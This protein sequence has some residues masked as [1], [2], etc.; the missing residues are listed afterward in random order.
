MKDPEADLESSKAEAYQQM[1]IAFSAIGALKNLLRYQVPV[2]NYV[3]INAV[4][5]LTNHLLRG[6]VQLL[7]KNYS[8]YVSEIGIE[9]GE[10]SLEEASNRLRKVEDFIKRCQGDESLPNNLIQH[11]KQYI[12]QQNSLLQAYQQKSYFNDEMVQS[13]DESNS[14]L[15]TILEVEDQY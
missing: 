14:E 15:H 11:L 13:F 10:F 6:D 4:P 1:A 5:D 8:N 9:G 12:E 7:I 3:L 2:A